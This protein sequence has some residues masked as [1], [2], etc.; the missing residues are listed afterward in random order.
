[1]LLAL[2]KLMSQHVEFYVQILSDV[3]LPEDNSCTEPLSEVEIGNARAGYSLLTQFKLVPG[4]N[5]GKMDMAALQTWITEVRALAT[6]AARSAIADT[7]I[8]HILAHSP[9]E[10]GIWPPTPVRRSVVGGN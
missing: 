2:H 5:A 8:G 3:F 6:L 7:Y 1:V 4:E 10:S 9:P